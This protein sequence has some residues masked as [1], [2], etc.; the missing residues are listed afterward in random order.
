[1]SLPSAIHA[2][3]QLTPKS[4]QPTGLARIS[5]LVN[6]RN[7]AKR[8]LPRTELVGTPGPWVS[9]SECPPRQACYHADEPAAQ[10][11]VGR[12]DASGCGGRGC[13]GSHGPE[14]LPAQHWTMPLD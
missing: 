3:A 14:G 9:V 7:R 11:A 10:R 5:R 8:E 12:L 13:R 6:W 1:M 4:D 2:L